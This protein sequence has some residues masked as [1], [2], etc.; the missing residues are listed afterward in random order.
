MWTR[1]MAA[2]VALAGLLTF[3]A[4]PG[5]LATEPVVLG[6][7][8]EEG[9]SEFARCDGFTIIDQYV[10]VFSQ[11]RY[12]DQDGRLIRIIEDVSGT[13]TLIN[14][15]NGKSYTGRFHNTVIIDPATRL[16]ATSGIIYRITV[17]GAGA[18]LLDVGRIVTDRTGT[19]IAFQ[20]GPHQAFDGDFAGICRVLA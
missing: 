11:K 15:T 10:V 14:P 1:L 3:A 20:A 4:H 13:D 18:V 5:V 2:S 19:I 12:F 6:P 9:T 17:P 7:F 8:R 16:G